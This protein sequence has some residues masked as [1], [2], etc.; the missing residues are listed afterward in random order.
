MSLTATV[1]L[2]WLASDPRASRV[3]VS[4]GASV[5][6]RG[7]RAPLSANDR[8]QFGLL[9]ILSPNVAMEAGFRRGGGQLNLGYNPVIQ[10][11]W[12]NRLGLDRPLLLHQAYSNYVQDLSER[13]L[14]SVNLAGGLGETDYSGLAAVIGDN[15]ET[16]DARVTRFASTSVNV[17]LTGLLTRRVS[18]TMQPRFSYRAPISETARAPMNPD[19]DDDDAASL[20]RQLSAGMMMGV[21][22]RATR[23]D[24][25]SVSTVPSYIS[26]RSG[27]TRYA[28]VD[29]RVAWLRRIRGSLSTTLD[30]G[31]FAVRTYG[32]G[33]GFRLFP[34]GGASINGDLRRRARYRITGDIDGQI[35][36]FFDRVTGGIDPRA[37]VSAGIVVE[38][39]PRWM[40]RFSGA[41]VTNATL[42]PRD[43]GEA[44]ES[45][46]NLST[47]VT[48]TINE[49]QSF[50]FG[51]VLT[52]R[53]PHLASNQLEFRQL[54]TWLYVA[55]RVG[56]GT[57][58][59]GE[60]VTSSQGPIGRTTRGGG[61]QSTS[62]RS[63]S[64]RGSSR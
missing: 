42:T 59:G 11:R 23:R 46:I 12:P 35:S 26:N 18:F 17:S 4:G 64:S 53:A 55:Y 14:L 40:V 36:G 38:L 8:P 30:A 60:E 52:V 58:R 47:P 13:W 32:E 24:E 43:N 51:T 27:E 63:R 9:T 28:S 29:S 41:A 57:A 10:Y 62:G 39:P 50:E 34:A 45:T 56:V 16:V 20:P 21:T 15:A 22:T 31:T 33:G 61:S 7:G 2:L 1:A 37:S 48:Y 6:L 3:D 49:R 19:D 5:E 44:A 54:E 25:I